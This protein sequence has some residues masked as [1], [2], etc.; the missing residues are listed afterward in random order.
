MRYIVILSSFDHD[1]FDTVATFDAYADAMDYKRMLDKFLCD[2]HE[3]FYLDSS[4]IIVQIPQHRKL[5]STNE[6]EK[7]YLDELDN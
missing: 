2:N 7:E 3:E 5:M 1:L 6:I 4:T